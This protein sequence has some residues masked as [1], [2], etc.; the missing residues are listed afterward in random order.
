MSPSQPYYRII[1]KL[2][3][4]ISARIDAAI[5]T[6]WSVRLFGGRP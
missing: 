2:W 5:L 4:R 6:A 1:H 3:A